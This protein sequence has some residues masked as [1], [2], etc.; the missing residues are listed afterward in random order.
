MNNI[1][2]KIK[3]SD[4]SALVLSGLMGLVFNDILNIALDATVIQSLTNFILNLL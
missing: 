3:N 4:N 1:I 2:D